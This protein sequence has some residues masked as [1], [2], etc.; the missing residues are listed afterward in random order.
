M[1]QQQVA[2]NGKMGLSHAVSIGVG[3]MIGAG[4]FSVMGV[5]SDVASGKTPPAALD[6]VAGAFL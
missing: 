3:G 1:S 6:E 5:A 4:V 2:K